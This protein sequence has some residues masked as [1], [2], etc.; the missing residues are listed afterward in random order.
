MHRRKELSRY[1][2]V[3]RRHSTSFPAKVFELPGCHLLP[4]W[5]DQNSEP[6]PSQQIS[7]NNTTER[8]CSSHFLHISSCGLYSTS[9]SAHTMAFLLNIQLTSACPAY[10]HIPRRSLR[11]GRTSLPP[12]QKRPHKV[13]LATDPQRTLAHPST[14]S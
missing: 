14:S 13:A 10:N 4:T 3:V 1:E 6:G 2:Q 5:T 12:T 8:T 7:K 9:K 11:L